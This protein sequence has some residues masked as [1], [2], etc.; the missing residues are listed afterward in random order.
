V[1]LAH[2]ELRARGWSEATLPAYCKPPAIP[3]CRLVHGASKTIT[4]VEMDTLRTVMIYMLHLYA[5]SQ[6]RGLSPV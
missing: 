4:L 2:A 3:H 6:A 5:A 1:M